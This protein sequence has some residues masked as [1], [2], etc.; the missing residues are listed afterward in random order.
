MNWNFFHWEE[1]VFSPRFFW[2]VGG[3]GGV[4]DESGG[5]GV[6]GEWWCW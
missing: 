1:I 5:D 2:G 6:N 4:V 3:M